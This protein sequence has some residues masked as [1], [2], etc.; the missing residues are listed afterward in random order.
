MIR[1]LFFSIALVILTLVSRICISQDTSQVLKATELSIKEAIEIGIVELKISGAYDPSMY[2]EMVDQ[3]DVHYG[4]CMVILLKS[5]ID[6]IVYLRLDC[7]IQLIPEDTAVQT[8]IVTRMAV[9]PLYP[10]EIYSTRFYA[11]CGQI[12]DAAPNI[13]TTF[14]VGELADSGMVKLAN[15]LGKHFIQ[16]LPGQHAVWAYGDQVALTELE[17][18]GADSIS[19]TKTIEILKILNLKTKL[20]P[21]D[22][23]QVT[24]LDH[25]SNFISINRYYVYVGVGLMVVLVGVVVRLKNNKQQEEIVKNS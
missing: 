2:L 13:E 15:Y 5:K 25:N 16:N 18:Y 1:S 7:G 3:D 23:G 12:H 11:M 17:R 20:T 21:K 14:K 9:F 4:K 22:A 10:N 19:L 8:M 24:Q 6:S